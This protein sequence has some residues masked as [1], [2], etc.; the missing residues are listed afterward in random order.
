MKKKITL[1]AIGIFLILSLMFIEYRFI[2]HNIIPYRGEGG[3][4]YLEI[5]GYTDTYYADN[6]AEN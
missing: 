4:V 5:F 1:V 2:M 6:I 3:T